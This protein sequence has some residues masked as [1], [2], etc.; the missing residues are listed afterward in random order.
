MNSDKIWLTLQAQCL[1]LENRNES[2]SLRAGVGMLWPTV[3]TCPKLVFV[4]LIL[5]L[6]V[7]VYVL[8]RF[9]FQ[10]RF[11]FMGKLWRYYKGFV[12]IPHRWLSGK[13]FTTQCRSWFNPWVRKILWRRKWQS[14]PV[15]LPGIIPWIEEPGGLQSTELQ[16]VRYD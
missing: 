2:S 7:A 3:Q 9:L 14:T 1:Q 11:W 4:L 10:N 5:Q 8:M 13:E 12:F 16:R 6:R 15:L